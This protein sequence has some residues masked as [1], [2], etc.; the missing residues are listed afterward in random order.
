MMMGPVDEA[1]P[2]SLI[3]DHPDLEVWLDRA[4][5]SQLDSSQLPDGAWVR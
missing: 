4:A 1:V 3:R 2:A 5:A